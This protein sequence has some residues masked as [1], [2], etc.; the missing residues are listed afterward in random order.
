MDLSVENLI[1]DEIKMYVTE[2]K[3]LKWTCDIIIL[4]K[5]SNE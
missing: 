5:I 3:I 2:M 4:D 1:K